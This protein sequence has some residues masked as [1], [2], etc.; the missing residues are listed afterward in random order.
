MSDLSKMSVEDIYSAL[1][2]NA[3]T[4]EAAFGELARHLREAQ[5]DRNEWKRRAGEM[6]EAIEQAH[7]VLHQCPELN[8]SNYDEDQVAELNGAMITAFTILDNIT[9]Q[10]PTGAEVADG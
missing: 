8:M 6:G 10:Q 3:I 7:T 2:E 4:I 1:C 5:A 9:S